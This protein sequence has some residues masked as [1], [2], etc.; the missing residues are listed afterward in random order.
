MGAIYNCTVGSHK[1]DQSDG[2][3]WSIL[4]RRFAASRVLCD[5]HT[6]V[7]TLTQTQSPAYKEFM[8]TACLPSPLREP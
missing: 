8:F 2:H 7:Q 6:T 5:S 4:Y 1:S 3:H